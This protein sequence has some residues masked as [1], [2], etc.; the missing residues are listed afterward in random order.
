LKELKRL[1]K[2]QGDQIKMTHII[3]DPC[4]YQLIFLLTWHA[5]EDENEFNWHKETMERFTKA[6]WEK[7]NPKVSFPQA[8]L[9]KFLQI[10]QGQ[11][12]FGATNSDL[13]SDIR[14]LS[15][16]GWIKGTLL[17]SELEVR[18][19][20]DILRIQLGYQLEGEKNTESYGAI[21]KGILNTSDLEKEASSKHSYVGGVYYPAAELV[22]QTDK[23]KA[24]EIALEIF[25]TLI[26]QTVDRYETLEYD[27]G[28]LVLH[29]ERKEMPAIL[30]RENKS[31]NLQIAQLVHWVLPH[32]IMNRCKLNSVVQLTKNSRSKI[33]D[34]ERELNNLCQRTV[35]G[36]DVSP[37]KSVMRNLRWI[38]DRTLELSKARGMFLQELTNLKGCV[39]EIETIS[40]AMDELLG[41]SIFAGE[42]REPLEYW[43]KDIGFVREQLKTNLDFYI[44]SKE[45]AD[46]ALDSLSKIAQIRGAQWMRRINFLTALVTSLGVV[47]IF[48]DYIHLWYLQILSI[49]GLGYVLYQILPKLQDWL[50]V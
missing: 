31:Y 43:S 49:F 27:W 21:K 26:G 6:S 28:F 36:L 22:G 41:R 13:Y 14:V 11:L 50:E 16:G 37:D 39:K 24:E 20:D 34:R 2:E 19:Y 10:T 4:I 12:F 45:S 8:E 40:Q 44:L 38:E 30:Y 35:S 48:K 32:I 7:T 29:P 23:Q 17:S 18:S 33:E 3:K 42:G 9:Q 15:T 46:S 25:D 1:C 5:S 47:I